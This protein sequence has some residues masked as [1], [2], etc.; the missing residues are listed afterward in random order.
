MPLVDFIITHPADTTRSGFELTH[1]QCG[2]TL[3]DITG[4]ESVVTLTAAAEDHVCPV[5]QHWHVQRHTTDENAL[6]ERFET[7][8]E[9][10]RQAAESLIAHG[11]REKTGS[12][13][14]RSAAQEARQRHD[15]V[16]ELARYRDM[17]AMNANA[18]RFYYLAQ[19]ASTIVEHN[20]LPVSSDRRAPLYRNNQGALND[21]AVDTVAVLNAGVQP[22]GFRIWSGT[23]TCECVATVDATTMDATTMDA[24]NVTVSDPE[25]GA[26]QVT[27]NSDAGEFTCRDCGASGL[28]DGHAA[29]QDGAQGWHDQNTA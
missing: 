19:R 25:V 1:D 8:F 29:D 10:L 4:N 27:H 7:V 3:R 9:A 17:D 14:N 22:D 20:D 15:V 28:D 6:T 26:H 13:S 12:E 18:H 11:D 5:Q 24:F 16:S 23:R 2:E 21:A